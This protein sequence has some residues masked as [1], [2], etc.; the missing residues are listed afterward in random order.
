V[1]LGQVDAVRQLRAAGLHVDKVQGVFDA[2]PLGTV[3]SQ[4]PDQNFF[5]RRG[6]SVDLTV[7]RGLEMTRVPFL[8]GLAQNEAAADLEAA[9]LVLK[10]VSRD[11]NYPAGQVLDVLPAPGTVL[12]ARSPV[13]LVVAS[14]RVQVPDVRGLDQ[15][16]AINRLGAE[17]FAIGIRSVVSTAA[18]GTVIGQSPVNTLVLRG[19]DVILDVA[20]TAPSPS[21]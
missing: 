9:K 4:S 19:S 7:S 3:L 17:G 15:Q 5:V 13:T 21:P 20:N 8:V 18:P 16:S 10:T 14:G 11:G 6:G 2:K 1:G 12:A